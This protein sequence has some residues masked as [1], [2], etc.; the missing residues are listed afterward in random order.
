ME[1]L[2]LEKQGYD[3]MI[4][5]TTNYVNQL[6]A[7]SQR[8]GGTS[9][10]TTGTRQ[11]GGYVSQ[12]LWR[13]HSGE[14]VMN[15]KTTKAAERMTGGRLSQSSILAGIMGGLGGGRNV[16]VTQRF[17][18]HGSMSDAEKQWYKRTARNEAYGAV[19]DALGA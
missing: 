18:F 11:E 14:Y 6:I 16:T 1:L 9:T 13:L 4:A 17:T 12:G 19:A 2:G 5:Q 10:S 3:A 15:A 7:Q 8:L